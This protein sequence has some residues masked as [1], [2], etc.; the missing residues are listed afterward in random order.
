MSG[1]RLEG[2]SKSY[3]RVPAV[4]DCSLD[5]PDGQLLGLLGPSGCGKTTLLRLL[6]GFLR[7]DV[8][9]IWIGGRDVAGLPPFRRNIGFMFQSY[10]LFPHLT[11]W[12]NVAFGLRMR[13]RFGAADGARDQVRRYLDLVR[14]PGHDDRYPHQL[15]GG[16]Q[17]RVALARA[18]AIE[19]DVLL[20]D[21]PLGSL[22]KKL[23]EEMQGELKALQRTLG[24]T[25]IFVTHDQEEALAMADRVAVMRAGRIEQVGTPG[26][27]YEAPRTR[28]V[29]DFIGVGNYF[30][31]TILGTAAGRAR[32]RTT[33]GV[34]LE[35]ATGGHDPAAIAGVMVRPEKIAVRRDPPPAG[36]A[37]LFP[38]TVADL[39]Y[40]GTFTRVVAKLGAG[41]VTALVQNVGPAGHG[42]D[43]RRGQTVYLCI[44]PESFW[45]LGVADR[46]TGRVR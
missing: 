16:Q 20:L 13:R 34:E 11:V 22:D 26:E 45:V 29:S 4:V 17:Q 8:G 23:R 41:D 37:N 6:G 36:C 3:G 1:L 43:L 2:V 46:P 14:L 25:T 9:G 10:A 42:G 18:L 38:S 21:E 30:E 15:S 12:D 35:L 40:Q 19:P 33:T 27:I 28:F 44:D 24:V 31:G 39:V 32:L 5:V 7:P